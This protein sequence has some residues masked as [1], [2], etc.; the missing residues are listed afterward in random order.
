MVARIHS[1]H[2]V[3]RTAL[4][5]T[6][7]ARLAY[8]PDWMLNLAMRP[9]LQQLATQIEQAKRDIDEK[10]KALLVYARQKDILA[11]DT[12]TN[13]SGERLGAFNDDYAVT[14]ADRVANAHREGDQ[15]VSDAERAAVEE[16]AAALGTSGT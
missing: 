7:K 12:K 8:A 3:L 6:N 16:I 4:A 2:T 13:P 14:V 15:Q 5:G 10:E 1:D 11:V 9:L